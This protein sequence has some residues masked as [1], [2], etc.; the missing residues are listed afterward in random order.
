MPGAEEQGKCLPDNGVFDCL[1]LGFSTCMPCPMHEYFKK[2]AGVA[3]KVV[4]A[5][6]AMRHFALTPAAQGA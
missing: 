1:L 6:A 3:A 4:P 5:P 2:H